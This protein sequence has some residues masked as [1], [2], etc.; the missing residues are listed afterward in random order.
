MSRV[1]NSPEETPGARQSHHGPTGETVHGPPPNPHTRG[2]RRQG[3]PQCHDR[4]S[5]R[6]RS[7]VALSIA[8]PAQ[9][10]QAG[11]AGGY[12]GQ[13]DRPAAGSG[14]G[15]APSQ[16][17]GRDAA[18][19]SRFSGRDAAHPG[20]PGAHL[21]G[22][23]RAGTRRDLPP[24][25]S[26]G[27]ARLVGLHRRQ[28][29]RRH[30]RGHP[31]HP[32]A[33]SLPAGVLWLAACRRGVGRRKLRCAGRGTTECIV[34][35]GRCAAR[36]PQRQPLSSIPKSGPRRRRRPDRALRSALCPLRHDRHAQQPR[37]CAREWCH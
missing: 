20:A 4:R 32:Q 36:A 15:A 24:G 3:G 23:A 22:A 9:S 1:L 26:A 14:A 25:A 12:M 13:R 31:V 34:G 37:C 21:A 7:P 6:C 17:D 18:S 10:P 35:V 33:L 30:H 8:D 29:P 5:D 16:H 28:S 2:R 27:A 19:A 11:P